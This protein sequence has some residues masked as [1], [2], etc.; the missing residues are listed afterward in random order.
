LGATR[1]RP[2]SKPTDD[3]IFFYG[4]PF[5]RYCVRCTDIECEILIDLTDRASMYRRCVYASVI[6]IHFPRNGYL[7]LIRD[8]KT[9]YLLEFIT[10]GFEQCTGLCVRLERC[11]ELINDRSLLITNNIGFINT[12][13]RIS[14]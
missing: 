7:I 6:T 8:A 12:H 13:L 3:E 4:L 10:I 2:T 9:Q 14:I 11:F 1:P 5:L